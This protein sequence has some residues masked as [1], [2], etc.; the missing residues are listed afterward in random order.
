MIIDNKTVHHCSDASVLSQ[1]NNFF[2]RPKLNQH[3]NRVVLGY[4]YFVNARLTVYFIYL[5]YA[6]AITGCKKRCQQLNN[7]N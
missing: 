2:I 3:R 6:T 1:A 4:S 7:N 5:V